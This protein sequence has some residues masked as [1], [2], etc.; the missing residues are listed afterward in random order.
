MWSFLILAAL[1]CVFSLA[2]ASNFWL[3]D[4]ETLDYGRAAYALNEYFGYTDS[5]KNIINDIELPTEEGEEDDDKL[6]EEERKKKSQDVQRKR[7][8]IY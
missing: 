3:F 2:Y 1:T 6:P 5:D 8:I 7:C 4:D